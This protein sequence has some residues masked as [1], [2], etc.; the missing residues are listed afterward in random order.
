MSTWHEPKSGWQEGQI[1]NEADMNEI[2][3]NLAYLY[4]RPRAVGALATTQSTSSESFTD[5]HSDLT[6]SLEITTGTVLVGFS[7]FCS[8]VTGSPQAR[9]DVAVDGTQ[10]QPA[11]GSYVF[12]S[13]TSWFVTVSFV[14]MITGLS[15]GQREFKLRWRVEDDATEVQLFGAG[16]AQLWVMEI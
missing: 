9:L 15:P 3:D 6:V 10:L 16:R 14:R 4:E 11:T 2:G 1:V 8:A 7:G 13:S 12:S 5:V